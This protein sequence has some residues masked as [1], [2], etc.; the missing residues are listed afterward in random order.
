M[1]FGGSGPP[2]RGNF[3]LTDFGRSLLER[4]RLIG[5]AEGGHDDSSADGDL[6]ATDGVREDDAGCGICYGVVC[7]TTLVNVRS[8]ETPESVE[9]KSVPLCDTH[10][11]ALHGRRLAIGY[12]FD[13]ARFGEA[14]TPSPCGAEYSRVRF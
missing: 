13:C 7:D 5:K 8:L 2:T 3:V 9:Q 1:S 10:L 14:W 4:M 12:C 11:K 6:V